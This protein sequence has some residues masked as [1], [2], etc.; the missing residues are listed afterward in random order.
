MLYNDKNIVGWKN[1]TV[2]SN[3]YNPADPLPFSEIMTAL[4]AKVRD[5]L[6]R[7][8]PVKMLDTADANGQPRGIVCGSIFVPDEETLAIGEVFMNVTKS[9]LESNPKAAITVAFGP[10]AYNINVSVI[11][12]SEEGEMLDALNGRLSK[13]NLSAKAVWLFRV[14]SVFDEGINPNAG[15]LIS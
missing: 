13:I 8:E 14:E 12:R 15:K 4:P 9:N 1:G 2:L 7:P 6:G 10:E 3:Q 11:S 5:F